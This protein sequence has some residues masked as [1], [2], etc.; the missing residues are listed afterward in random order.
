MK[1]IGIDIGTTT[2]SLVVMDMETKRILESVTAAN[3]TFL[4]TEKDWERIQ[5]PEKTVKKA[6]DILE[7]LLSRHQD[8]ASIGLTGQMHG[9]LYVDSEGECVSP[10]YTWQDG[11]GD[12]PEFDGKSM[13]G[14]V[15][16]ETGEAVSTGYGLV[17][18]LYCS[19]KRTVPESAVSFCTISDYLGMKLTGRKMPLVHVSNAAGF[20]LFDQ[21]QLTFCRGK[22]EKLGMDLQ[23]LPPV[24]KEVTVLGQYRGIPVTAALGDNQAGFLGTV[25][26]C[27]DTVLLNMGTGGQISVLSDQIPDGEG[28]ESR[29]FLQGKYILVGAS[30]CGGRA[31]AVLERFFRSFYMRA[32][33]EDRELYDILESLA[34]DGMQ[35]EDPLNVSTLFHGTRRDPSLRG[36]ITNISDN[37]FTPEAMT[38]GVLYGMVRE[39]YDQYQQIRQATGIRAVRLIGSGNGLRKNRVL[40]EISSQMFGVELSLAVNQEEAA[41]GAAI[42]SRMGEERDVQ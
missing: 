25:G 8:I 1:A 24:T 31:Y 22:L 11:R 23:L 3:G 17:T 4:E 32:G 18:H 5:D 14:L 21:K 12:L 2:I 30:L 13:A 34:R 19:R 9:I 26:F 7:Q 27:K 20:G 10:L 33:G 38:Y 28:I 16:E 37:N 29:P 15:K 39:L 35:A 36:S 40:Q 6:V 41:C 42:S